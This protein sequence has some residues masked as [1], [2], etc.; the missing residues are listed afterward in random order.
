MD[1]EKACYAG[2]EEGEGELPEDSELFAAQRQNV[3]ACCHSHLSR[4]RATGK[5]PRH[6]KGGGAPAIEGEQEVS[7]L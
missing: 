7:R 1:A 4:R 2:G 6:E 3:T 5:P